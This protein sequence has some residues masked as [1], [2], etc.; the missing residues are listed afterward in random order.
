MRRFFSLP[1]EA[2]K[3]IER[4]A[5]NAWGYFDRELTK[6]RQD[7]KQIFDFGPAEGPAEAPA[8]GPAG[9]SAPLA[10][11]VLRSRSR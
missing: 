2:K 3:R 6:N 8:E 11:I 5:E 1:G 9:S 4:S 7:W 10:G